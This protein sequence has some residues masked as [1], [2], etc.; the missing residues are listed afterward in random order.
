MNST[1]RDNS[2]EFSLQEIDTTAE[3]QNS[4]YLAPSGLTDSPTTCLQTSNISTIE[5]RGSVRQFQPF[6][7]AVGLCSTTAGVA[8]IL[9]IGFRIIDGQKFSADFAMPLVAICIL[10][11]VMLLGGGFGVM[12]TSSSGFDEAEFDRLA[13]AGNISSAT[14]TDLECSDVSNRADTQ[15]AAA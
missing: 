10:T 5:S 2:Q 4:S 13:A 7:F 15:Q 11:G 8:L 6:R 14:E 9:A 3:E 1:V 12:A